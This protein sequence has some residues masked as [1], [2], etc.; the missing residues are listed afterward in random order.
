[1]SVDPSPL[2][3]AGADPVPAA[4]DPAEAWETGVPAV[5]SLSPRAPATS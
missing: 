1:M 3:R 2:S 4:A 5:P